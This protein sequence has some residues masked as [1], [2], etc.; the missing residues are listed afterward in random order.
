M[1]F[2]PSSNFIRSRPNY[3]QTCYI[4]VFEVL[5]LVEECYAYC[6]LVCDTKFSTLNSLSPPLSDLPFK[7]L[8][9][10]LIILINFNFSK[11]FFSWFL[12]SKGYFQSDP[13]DFCRLSSVDNQYRNKRHKMKFI[14]QRKRTAKN[15][16]TIIKYHI[17]SEWWNIVNLY[18]SNTSN[19]MC[20]CQNYRC[21]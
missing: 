16:G 1:P 3:R 7:L 14:L 5:L 8:I 21:I 15:Q 4:L 19:I 9:I 2:Q 17:I 20:T 6:C 18:A 10:F 13:T 11:L 12:V